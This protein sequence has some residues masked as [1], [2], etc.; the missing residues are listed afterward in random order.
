MLESPIILLA[1]RIEPT[2]FGLP[3]LIAWVLIWWSFCTIIFFIAYKLNWGRG[4]K[5]IP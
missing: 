4:K 1:N 5:H 2:I 3:F